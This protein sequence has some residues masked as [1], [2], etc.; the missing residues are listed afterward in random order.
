MQ[1][2]RRRDNG[3]RETG[4]PATKEAANV[5]ETNR[6]R[7]TAES[8]PITHAIAAAAKGAAAIGQRLA[9]YSLGVVAGD[10]NWIVVQTGRPVNRRTPA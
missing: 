1:P 4:K 3:K 9:C 8:S 10:L 5:A 7:L 6:I 2:H